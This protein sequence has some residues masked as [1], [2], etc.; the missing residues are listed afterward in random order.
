MNET[1]MNGEQS[2]I[3]HLMM[4]ALDDECSQSERRELEEALAADEGLRREWQELQRVKEV[5]NTMSVR[6]APDQVWQEYWG[7]VYA[8]LERG[9]AWVFI[10][11]SAIVLIAW[12]IWQAI[13][14]LA[15][16][17]DVPSLVKYAIAA[18]AIGLAV[19]AVSV[20]REKLFVRK[21]DPYKDIE[22]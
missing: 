11:L 3:R 7:S 20:I 6:K 12:G 22:R 1:A 8:R 5:T 2:K 18:L 21:S 9:V 17:A 19:L 4:A 10:S 15:A 14:E 16:D 13:Q